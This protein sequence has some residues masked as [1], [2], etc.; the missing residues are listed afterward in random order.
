[1]NFLHLLS[2]EAEQRI[3]IHCLNV[4]VWGSAPTQPPLVDTARFWAWNGKTLQP[5]VPEDTCWQRD[6]RW[7]R[8]VFLFKVTDASL[9]PIKHISN[10]PEITLS[11]RYHLEVGPVCFL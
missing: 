1:I 6:G 2:S 10:L 3:T 4:S 9:L 11:S 8:T 5:S 7:Q